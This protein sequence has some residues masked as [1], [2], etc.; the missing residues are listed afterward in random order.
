MF[1]NCLFAIQ[2]TSLL[3]INRYRFDITF[4]GQILDCYANLFLK[5]F[6]IPRSKTP[7]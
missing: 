4:A 2:K 5:F 6:W 3:S 1:S 7:T